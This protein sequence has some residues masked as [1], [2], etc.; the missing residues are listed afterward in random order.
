[1]RWSQVIATVS[2]LMAAPVLAQ[3]P[4]QEKHSPTTGPAQYVVELA[5]GVQAPAIAEQTGLSWVRR[6]SDG[7]MG[8]LQSGAGT[9]QRGTLDRLRAMPGVTSAGV[10]VASGVTRHFSLNDPFFE[11]GAGGQGNFGQWHLENAH[12]E[13]RDVNAKPAWQRGLTGAGTTIGVVDTGIETSHPDLAPN[14]SDALSRFFRPGLPGGRSP[15]GGRSPAEVSDTGDPFIGRH[16]TAVAGLAAARGGNGEGVTGAAPR[17]TLADLSLDFAA[18]DE[19]FWRTVAEATRYRASAFDVKNHSYGRVGAYVPDDSTVMA[20]RAAAREGV[21]NVR[22]AGNSATNANTLA[23]Q[24]DRTAITVAALSMDGEASGFSNFGPN[25][26]VTAPSND[27][28]GLP[29]LTTTDRTG[30]AGFNDGNPVFNQPDYTNAFGGTSGSAPIVAG[31]VAQIKQVNPDLGVR[32]VKHVLANTSRKVDAED[33]RW[34]TNG[35]GF[36]FNPEY[37]FGLVDAGAATRFAEGFE[38]KPQAVHSTG[39]IV[40]NEPIPDPESFGD[41]PDPV[42]VAFSL[43]GEGAI[44]TVELALEADHPFPGDFALS[45]ESPAGT[46]SALA[47]PTF[48]SRRWDENT[49]EWTFTSAAF[50]GEDLTGEWELALADRLAEDAGVFESFN[51]TAF[52]AVPE[53]GSV[54]LML[55]GAPALLGRRRRRTGGARGSVSR[56]VSDA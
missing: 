3:Q 26:F 50:W 35:A 17:A 13:G 24:A 37:G 56:P 45:L 47:S 44:E 28:A 4:G 10:S 33:A 1:M 46:E 41:Q 20:N 39:E 53:P 18:P 32:G 38:P 7:G 6:P 12:V 34:Q 29:L 22:S 25:V 42:E 9:W 21:V 15:G 31:V 5:P 51:F 23:A 54:A 36:E 52:T 55:V 48:S 2:V 19:A 27:T 30:S 40:V 16:G 43:A 49:F 8:F 11:T 14:S